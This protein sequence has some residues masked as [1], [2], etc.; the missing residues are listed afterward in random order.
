MRPEQDQQLNELTKRIV[1]AVHPLRIILFGSAARDE[2]HRESDLDIAVVVPEGCD[3]H[4]IAEILY[5]KLIGLRVAVA[6][7][8]V[9]PALL[10]KYQSFKSLI[11]YDIV[12]DGR[13]LYAA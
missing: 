6:L 3:R 9:T 10:A 8:I 4:D 2:M 5:P 13:E 7:L 1:D 11:Y 12:R